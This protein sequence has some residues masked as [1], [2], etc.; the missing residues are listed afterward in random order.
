MRDVVTNGYHVRKK[1][2]SQEYVQS[3]RIPTGIDHEGLANSV[4]KEK[5]SKHRRFI[6]IRL[7]IFLRFMALPSLVKLARDYYW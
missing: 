4:K 3:A 7:L 1:R 6:K 5:I 2:R